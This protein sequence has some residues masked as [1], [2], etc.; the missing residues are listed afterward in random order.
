M[1]PLIGRKMAYKASKQENEPTLSVTTLF[2]CSMRN[3]KKRGPCLGVAR[4]LENLASC[5]QVE[6]THVQKNHPLLFRCV[7]LMM[8]CWF[9][10]CPLNVLTNPEAMI[11]EKGCSH[12]S[13]IASLRSLDLLGLKLPEVFTTSCPGQDFWVL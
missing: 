8:G 9:I 1:N 3:L 2:I 5:S 13:M 4:T 10:C 12:S 11:P 7:I 6:P